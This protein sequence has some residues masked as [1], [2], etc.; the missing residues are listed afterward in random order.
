MKRKKRFPSR[1]NSLALTEINKEK[2]AKKIEL[3]LLFLTLLSTSTFLIL[4]TSH[5][6]ATGYASY[7][8]SQAGYITE[9]TI[10]KIFPTTYWNGLYGLAFRVQNFT[11]MLSVDLEGEI[12]RQDLFFDCID[13]SDPNGNEIYASTSETVDFGTLEP[14]TVA[15]ANT[16]MSC[17]GRLD[18]ADNTFTQN[19]SIMLG[20]QNITGI[21]ST[22]TYRWDGENEIFDIG[23]MKDGSGDLV[24]VTHISTFQKGYSPNVTV[25]YQMLLPTPEN[26]TLTYYFYTDPYDECPVGGEAGNVVEV[27]VSGYVKD[28]LGNPIDNATVI[29]IG[30]IIQTDASGWYNFTETVTEGGYNIITQKTGYDDSFTNIAVTFSNFTFQ[31]NITL[32][33]ETPSTSTLYIPHIEGYVKDTSGAGLYDAKVSIGGFS[34]QSDF[35]GYYSIFPSIIPINQTIIA[36][37]SGYNNNFT[38]INFSGEPPLVSLN[39]TLSEAIPASENLFFE[40][41][42][43]TENK[44]SEIREEAIKNGDDYWI[45]TKEIKKEIRKNTFLEE[46]I[47][48]YNFGSEMKI[49]ITISTSLDNVVEIEQSHLTIPRNSMGEIP[50]TFYGIRDIGTYKGNLSI[51]GSLKQEIP[52]TV[53]IIERR[54][55]IETMLIKADIFNPIA[56]QSEDLKYK[57]TLQNLLSDQ[58]YIVYIDSKVVG[59]NNSEVY[60]TAKTQEEI[61]TSLTLLEQIKLPDDIP[62]GEYNLKIQAKYL[63]LVS[64]VTVP[65]KVAQPIYLYAFFGIPLWLY[66]AVISFLSFILLNF[67]V[68][69]RQMDKK[70]RYSVAVNYSELP[71]PGERTARLGHIAETSKEAYLELDKLT[72]HTIVAGATGMGKSISAQVLIEEALMK[73]VCVIVFDPTA[74]WSGLLRK[75]EDKKM[76]SFYP[77]FKMKASDARGFPGNIRAVKDARQVIDISKH[78]EPGHIQIFTLNKL[79]PKDMDIFVANIIRQIFKSD[80]KES[81]TLKTLIVFDEVH[82]LLPKFGGT[83]EGFLQIERGCREF[84]KWGLGQVLISQVM[85]DFVGE[86]KA[87]INTEIQTRTV[88]EG[89]L[90]RIKSKYGESFLKSLVKSEVG[91]AMFQNAEYNKGLPYFINF[92][93]ILHN[94]RRLSDEELEKYNKY[95]DQVDDLEYQVEQLEQLKIDVFDLKMELK[96]VKDKIMVGNFS[97]VDI[98]LEGLTPRII[99]QWEKLGKKPKKKEIE[100]AD[101]AEIKKSVEEAKGERAKVEA[102]EKVQKAEQKVIEKKAENINDKQLNA[103]TLDNGAMLSTLGELKDLLPTLD[104]EI[105]KLHVNKQKNE[106]SEWLKELS[107]ELAAK[108]KPIIDKAEMIEE[109]KTTAKKDKKPKPKPKK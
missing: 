88:E 49:D 61:A 34:V 36:T 73:N 99:K 46:S 101:L 107:P 77:K 13:T 91:V 6:L 85:G 98:Y 43:Y 1:A 58:G 10:D 100:L 20:A 48:V 97:V 19:M 106:I 60:V 93:P 87:N 40:T 52:I 41:G 102:K 59:A 33:E 80:P 31:E 25:N 4:F 35:F 65:F 56:R 72:V 8:D 95:N 66:L 9:V 108:I 71:G 37:L 84:R 96:L 3:F 44:F 39:L 23:L 92:R 17:S 83:G 75:C 32:Y 53:E 105:F 109:L 76:M 45:S 82:R 64:T 26:T 94:T 21:P 63:N 27:N 47:G 78:F 62:N 30:T 24:F 28:I 81:P 86:I 104:D 29:F 74:Q 7:L 2:R 18:C 79:Q 90:E 42:P 11:E 69:K 89:D 70:K 57:I 50:L 12:E 51:S 15:E 5:Y 68:Y 14:A 67:F 103:L 16:F 38:T 55:P 54:M 22:H